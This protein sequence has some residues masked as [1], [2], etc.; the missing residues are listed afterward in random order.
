MI[1]FLQLLLAHLAGDFFLQPTA[2]VKQKE[3]KN[4]TSPLLYYHIGIH[5]VLILFFRGSFEVAEPEY[6]FGSE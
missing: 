5:F 2:W 1:L 3:E 4:W 6:G